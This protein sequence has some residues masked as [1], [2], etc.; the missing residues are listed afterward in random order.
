MLVDPFGATFSF[1]DALQF[2][3][4]RVNVERERPDKLPPG[5]FKLDRMRALMK[6]LGNPEASLECVHVAGSKG[7]GSTVEMIAASLAGCGHAV[8]VYMS[9]HVVNIRERIRIGNEMIPEVMFARLVCRVWKSAQAI[10]AE[11]G[12]ATFFEILT[13][14]A[15]C[16]F[17]DEAVDLAVLEVGL[18]GRLDATNVIVPL[19][20]VITAI[21]MEH[22]DIL[23]DTLAKIAREK[24]GIMKRGVPCITLKQAPEVMEA[25]HA[26]AIEVG[27]PLWVVGETIDFSYRLESSPELGPHARVLLLT[28]TSTFEHFA[29]PLKGEH[30]ALNCGLALA[31]ID[32]LKQNGVDA[33]EVKVAAGLAK[34]VNNARFEQ[35]AD[36]PRI[37]VDGAHNPESIEGLIRSVGL[38]LRVDSTIIVFGCAADKDIPGMIR[39]L[40][41]GADK[42]IFTRASSSARAADPRE[43]ARKFE[44]ISGHMA[45]TAASVAEAIDLARR[46]ASRE[47]LILVTGSFYVAGEAKKLLQGSRQ[48]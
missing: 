7:K 40:A 35:V 42:V 10:I 13:A 48:Q 9:P 45:Q 25:F 46:A 24:A 17:A 41:R 3:D 4:A 38:H 31:A 32:I 12:E 34:A 44:A 30:Q 28:P 27:T 20:S 29:V 14:M 39:A 26:V 8:G 36:R 15:F 18:G 1:A 16:Y 6:A 47:D 33:P 19:V 11:E 21:Q 23:G 37:I 22:A 2:L 5:V 43:L